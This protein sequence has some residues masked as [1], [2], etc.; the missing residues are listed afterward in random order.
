M[1]CNDKTDVIRC[2]V[3]CAKW[4]GE[5]DSV[6]TTHFGYIV[7]TQCFFLFSHTVLMPDETDAKKILTAPLCRTGGDYQDTLVS[8][9]TWM[10]TVQQNLKS[11]N[12]SVNEA[13]NVARIVT[14]GDWCL[15]LVLCTPSG[16]CHKIRSAVFCATSHSTCTSHLGMPP[17]RQSAIGCR[18]FP[19][20]QHFAR[21]GLHCRE[22]RLVDI[23]CKCLFELLFR[24]QHL[25]GHGSNLHTGT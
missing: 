15:C 16:A 17:V 13:I 12:F 21:I 24:C 11:N 25:S 6:A 18:M 4:W 22:P 20:L 9:T 2:S 7:Q 10:K 5:T 23:V 8:C 1:Q 19:D 14:S 3:L